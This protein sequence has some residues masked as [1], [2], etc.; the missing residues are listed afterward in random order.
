MPVQG[1]AVGRAETLPQPLEK[2]AEE[3]AGGLPGLGALEGLEVQDDGA[4]KDQQGNI[5]GKITEGD[6]ADLVG[7]TLNDQG[8]ILDEDVSTPRC[9]YQVPENF[10][11]KILWTN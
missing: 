10:S 8:E 9:L 6:A 3:V 11:M 5:L 7:R 1:D 4:I 2:A